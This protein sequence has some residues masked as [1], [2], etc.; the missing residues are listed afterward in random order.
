MP[1][2][3]SFIIPVANE[4]FTTTAP[5]ITGSRVGNKTLPTGEQGRKANTGYCLR[6][7][8]WSHKGK[9]WIQVENKV[10]YIK[11]GASRWNLQICPGWCFGLPTLGWGWGI[12]SFPWIVKSLC[13]C[14]TQV[15]SSSASGWV[16]CRLMV[17]PLCWRS[18]SIWHKSLGPVFS[19]WLY[20]EQAVPVVCDHRLLIMDK[21]SGP[22]PSQR[23]GCRAGPP[24]LATPLVHAEE[25]SNCRF[26]PN[27][28]LN[29]PVILKW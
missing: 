21:D 11:V 24:F 20:S 14:E 23:K 29:C 28:N 5:V 15:E 26:Q 10:H 6:A 17:Q 18:S 16:D 27:L 4:T 13:G 1:H 8:C 12:L 9:P 2:W 25:H 22:P 3:L 7:Q 19:W